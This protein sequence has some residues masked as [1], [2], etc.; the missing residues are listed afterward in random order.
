WGGGGGGGGWG[1]GVLAE[2]ERAAA[3]SRSGRRSRVG[4][5]PARSERGSWPSRR[6][7]AHRYRGADRRRRRSA[8]GLPLPADRWAEP[9]ALARRRPLPVAHAER[10]A[11]PH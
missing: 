4:E 7:P 2:V 1:G 8:D 5:F 10:H 9:Q 6:I 3:A 11:R